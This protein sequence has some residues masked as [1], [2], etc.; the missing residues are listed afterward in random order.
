MRQCYR[1]TQIVTEYVD[2][3]PQNLSPEEQFQTLQECLETFPPLEREAFEEVL[4][5]F[6]NE[7][8]K[9]MPMTRELV[10]QMFEDVK[11]RKLNAARGGETAQILTFKKKP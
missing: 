2:E 5:W 1:K 9:D 3:D 11:R 4:L 6:A 7:K 10:E 8:P